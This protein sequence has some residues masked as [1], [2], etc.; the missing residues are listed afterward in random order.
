MES[1]R[2]EKIKDSIEETET[3]I[4]N[5]QLVIQGLEETKDKAKRIDERISI[6]IWIKKL[7]NEI[8]FLEDIKESDENCLSML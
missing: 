5:I 1:E 8:S 3:D 2:I 7:E 6:N 4:K